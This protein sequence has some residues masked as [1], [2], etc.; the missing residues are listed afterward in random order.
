MKVTKIFAAFLPLAF[1]ISGC[2][3]LVGPESS[4]LT[5]EGCLSCH[6]YEGTLLKYT[7]EKEDAGGSGGG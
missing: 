3:K 6:L 1:V 2:A 7:P 4:E 5:D